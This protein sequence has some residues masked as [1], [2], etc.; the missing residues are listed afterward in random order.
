MNRIIFLV[1]AFCGF[2]GFADVVLCQEALTAPTKTFWQTL[3]EKEFLAKTVAFIIGLQIM[4]YGISEGLTRIAVITENKWDNKA[5]AILSQ[6]AWWLGVVIG[7]FGYST[8]KL[9]IEEKAK[10][11][12]EKKGD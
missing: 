4:L 11:L 6:A 1:V 7:K 5:A 12:D 3:L 9:V 2:F 10:K 8:P